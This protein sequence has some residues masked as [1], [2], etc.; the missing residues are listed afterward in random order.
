MNGIEIT[1]HIF[2]IKRKISNIQS[3]KISRMRVASHRPDIENEMK[4]YDNQIIILKEEIAEWNIML[5]QITVKVG[6]DVWHNHNYKSG[7]CK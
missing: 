1:D 6:N 4:A 2:E 5:E 3:R 7:R